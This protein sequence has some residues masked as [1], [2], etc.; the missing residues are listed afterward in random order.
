MTMI[1][2]FIDSP[3]STS[4]PRP[5]SLAVMLRD[6]DPLAATGGGGGGGGAAASAP[7]FPRQRTAPGFIVRAL[8]L[9]RERGVPPFT[10]LS[11]DN[12]NH[13]GELCRRVVLDLADTID[14]E[15]GE[16]IREHVSFPSTMVDRITP[17][18]TPDHSALLR[19]D[20]GVHDQWPVVAENFRQWVVEDNFV[21]GRPAY[22][23][24]GVTM[25]R[26]HRDVEAYECMKLRL[27]N[28]VHSQ[29]AHLSY[30]CGYRYVDEAISELAIGTFARNYL[31]EVSLSVK[32][33]L[34]KQAL[35]NQ[36]D[37]ERY[38]EN[39][40]QR[41]RNKMIKDTL[42]RVA[43]DG[44]TKLY[45]TLRETMLDLTES[46]AHVN[47]LACGVAGYIVFMAGVDEKGADIP[48]SDP[49]KDAISPLCRAAVAQLGNED[50]VKEL[51][52]LVFGPD[53]AALQ[54]IV[55]EV[56][57]AVY[58]LKTF[59]V[60]RVLRRGGPLQALMYDCLN[61]R[62]GLA[63]LLRLATN[64]A[65]APHSDPASSSSKP[66]PPPPRPEPGRPMYALVARPTTTASRARRRCSETASESG[67]DD[68]EDEMEE[69]EEEKKKETKSARLDHHFPS[70]RGAPS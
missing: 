11:C 44:S 64:P 7:P 70:A 54:G 40:L 33:E 65:F 27:L 5:A 35:Q 34:Q 48:I 1:G 8:Q 4:T 13:N 68:D 28:G 51:M 62:T 23:A 14:P 53:I 26:H 22:E 6:R 24:V 20:F 19:G 57:M 59:G 29:I 15:L 61:A 38:K 17:A 9:R 66:P 36:V 25:V 50:R 69:E 49:K 55:R 37:V 52:C 3:H 43:I 21:S 12:L 46:D 60:L 39:I 32:A 63:E 67:G 42:E 47:H 30:L 10:V 31:D 41:F 56:T 58:A 2:G 18:T 45:N 16:W